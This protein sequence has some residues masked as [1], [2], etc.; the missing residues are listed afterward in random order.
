[1]ITIEIPYR[2]DDPKSADFDQIPSALLKAITTTREQYPEVENESLNKKRPKFW[3][4]RL[5]ENLYNC[6]VEY[7][8]VNGI[9]SI[10][11]PD[12]RDYT[13]FLLKWS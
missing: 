2:E 11:W 10:T 7:N 1:M 4:D 9:A 3:F 8:E 6:K 5:F 13:V 12:E